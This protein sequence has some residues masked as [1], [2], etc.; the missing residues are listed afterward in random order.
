MITSS[1]QLSFIKSDDSNKVTI[2]CMQCQT[3]YRKN[4][5]Y[6]CICNAQIHLKCTRG[7]A[8]AVRG[9]LYCEICVNIHDR[10][11]YN[12]FYETLES[13]TSGSDCSH[14]DDEPKESLQILEILSST[15]ESCKARKEGTI[16]IKLLQQHKFNITENKK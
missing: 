4:N 11:K 15:L 12:P 14:F 3:K 9:K 1:N 13:I 16:F 2:Q 8:I 7:G 6:C 10:K 5:T